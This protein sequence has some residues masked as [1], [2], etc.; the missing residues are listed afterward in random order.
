MILEMSSSV[1]VFCL[2]ETWLTE[3]VECC[4]LLL[5]FIFALFDTF[6]ATMAFY[7]WGQRAKQVD[8]GVS[9][10]TFVTSTIEFWFCAV[11]RSAVLA[12]AVIGHFWN[13]TDSQQRLQYTWPASVIVAVVMMMFAVV[14][15]LAYTEVTRSSAVFWFQ[16]AWMLVA[17]VAFH[18]GFVV[19][20]R[21]KNVNP[22][23]MNASINA[24]N[25][26]HEPL[27]PGNTGEETASEKTT[28]KKM[29]IV[30]RLIAYSKP[31]AYLI[32]IAFVFMVVSAVCKYY[33]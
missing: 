13:R 32:I 15:M 10:Y 3:M 29:S 5:L 9:S 18:A 12:G 23:V 30:F 8:I 31:D 22:I 20:R 19:L 17:S 24:E 16:F 14:K 4:R 28:P 2:Q 21:V 6:V 1:Y 11:I 7:V 26:E 25:G 27:L 33:C